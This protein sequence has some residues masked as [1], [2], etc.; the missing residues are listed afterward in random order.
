MQENLGNELSNLIVYCYDWSL[1]R[2]VKTLIFKRPTKCCDAKQNIT[3]EVL[4]SANIVCEGFLGPMISFT[5]KLHFSQKY[6]PTLR[7]VLI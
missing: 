6:V 5:V 3:S 7:K 2:V 4:L 1:V